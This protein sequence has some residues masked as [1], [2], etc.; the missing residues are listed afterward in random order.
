MKIHP[1]PPPRHRCDG[2]FL[3]TILISVWS[4]FAFIA[5]LALLFAVVPNVQS[6]IGSF[7]TDERKVQWTMYTLLEAT[8]YRILHNTGHSGWVL[9]FSYVLVQVVYAVLWSQ[10]LMFTPVNILYAPIV[11]SCI[12][13]VTWVPLVSVWQRCRAPRKR[14]RPRME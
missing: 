14:R 10:G 5:A 1:P 8:S 6:A 2:F 3:D 7:F 9:A 13:A 12:M 11:P 4:I